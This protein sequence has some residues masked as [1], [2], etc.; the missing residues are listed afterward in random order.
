MPNLPAAF[1]R[2][3]DHPNFN[4]TKSKVVVEAG[5]IFTTATF[6]DNLGNAL[7]VANFKPADNGGWEIDVHQ[8]S[9]LLSVSVV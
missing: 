2:E 5:D 9:P 3:Y 6:F 7:G 4:G 8:S 1:I